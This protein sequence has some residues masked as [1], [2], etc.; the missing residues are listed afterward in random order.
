MCGKWTLIPYQAGDHSWE[1]F[2]GIWPESIVWLV[3][4][5]AFTIWLLPRPSPPVSSTGDTQEDWERET[6]ADGRGDG[7]GAKSYDGEKAWS[8][9][10]IQYSLNPRIPQH[11]PTFFGQ[12]RKWKLPCWRMRAFWWRTGASL[13]IQCLC[14]LHCTVI[15]LTACWEGACVRTNVFNNIKRLTIHMNMALN[16]VML[17]LCFS[18]LYYCKMARGIRCVYLKWSYARMQRPSFG[19]ENQR[20]RENKPK[21]LV[22]IPTRARNYRPSFHENKPKTLVLYDWKRAFWACFHENWVYKF[23][24]RAQR[25]HFQLVLKT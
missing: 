17:C 22:F 11:S 25:P 19:H 1:I 3:E 21:T 10:G 2:K 6:L 5:Q 23:G 16:L 4:D 13:Y 15:C 9:I 7:L 24:H 12:M 18:K 14:F 20:F 8:S